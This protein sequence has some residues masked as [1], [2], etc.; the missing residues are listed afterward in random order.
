MGYCVK[1]KWTAGEL[2]IIISDFISLITE[3]LIPNLGF[4]QDD[5]VGWW[6]S[7]VELDG[8]DYHTYQTMTLT[9]T[10]TFG[11]WRHN[12]GL[13]YVQSL[14]TDIDMK[15]AVSKVYRTKF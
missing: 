4:F 14:P 10:L 7:Q 3:S 6:E 1:L 5:P 11:A 13:E 15:M 8:H 2:P 9:V 12:T